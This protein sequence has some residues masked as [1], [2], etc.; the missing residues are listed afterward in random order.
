MTGLIETPA[1]LD[2]EIDRLVAAA[3]VPEDL[4]I[5][6]YCAEAIAPGLFRKE[7]VY[8]LL[9]TYVPTPAIYAGEW[10]VKYS[11][12]VVVEEAMTQ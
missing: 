12:S 7:S 8:R 6:E 10:M 2:R 11:N 4:I 5:I 9:E 1:E 3:E